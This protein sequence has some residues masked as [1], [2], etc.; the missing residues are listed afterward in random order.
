VAVGFVRAQEALQVATLV[1]AL[2]D[3]DACVGDRSH[4]VLKKYNRGDSVTNF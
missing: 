1:L 4:R 2:G 3:Q